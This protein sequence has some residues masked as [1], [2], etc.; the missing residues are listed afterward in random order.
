MKNESNNKSGL[1]LKFLAVLGF[2]GIII[3]IS[4]FSVMLVN[5]MPTA[6][7][8]LASLA[9]G[10]NQQSFTGTDD[11]EVKSFVV[12]SDTT[13]INS[14]ESI[15]LSWD[16]NSVQGSYVFSYT[17]TDGVSL[18]IQDANNG[19]RNVACGA[20]YNIG[21]TN[22]VTVTVES[23]KSRFENI[24]Y[25]ISFLATN[26]TTPRSSGSASFTVINSSISEF[27]AEDGGEDSEDNNETE[28]V[29]D[30]EVAVEEPEVETPVTTPPAPTYEQEFI[31][32]IPVSDPNGKTDLSTRYLSSGNIIGNTFFVGAIYQEN[33]GAIQFEVK[34]YGTKTSSDWTYTMSL[35]GGGEYTSTKQSPLKPNERA[36][37]TL[38]FPTND[39][40]KHTF[41]V[42][43]D[44]ST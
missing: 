44:E 19:L 3:I 7:S 5:V 26:D 16:N 21:N 9:E 1:V 31:Y 42:S 4:W 18:D 20:N 23:E 6:F 14:G 35:P 29:T 28:V 2:I 30:P 12:S 33:S 38:G 24:N 17:C 10:L 34:N 37:I 41:V 15:D 8:S 36:V 13:L 22:S 43:I 27:A 40:S 39:D 11:K 32:S 25:T